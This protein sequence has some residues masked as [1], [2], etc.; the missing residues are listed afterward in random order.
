[1]KV[2][3]QN[4]EYLEILLIA[5][6]EAMDCLAVSVSCGITMKEFT[7]RDALMMATFFGGFQGGMT[8]VGWLSATNFAGYIGAFDHWVA[9]GLLV[10]I[11]AHMIKEG[12]ENKEE[13]ETFNIRKL[14]VLVFLSL[15]TSI[16]SVALGVTFAFLQE[17]MVVP[18]L[19]ISIMA[20]LFTIIGSG[21]GKKLG[22]LFGSRMEI[23]G[24]IIL[25]G[26]GIKIVLEHSFFV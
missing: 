17:P 10:I 2:I 19:T 6:A 8:L 18:I 11:G 13:S 3:Y 9:F 26:L 22:H 12:V 25:I 16:D 15:A 1:M 5:I 7:K 23:I 21:L 4:V 14:R 24:G 20:F